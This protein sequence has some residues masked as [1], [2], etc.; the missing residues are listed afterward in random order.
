MY[1]VLQNMGRVDRQNNA[2]PGVC[3][4]EVHISFDS[5]ISLYI[6]IMKGDDANER[7]QQLS[8]MMEVL[9]FLVTPGDCYHTLLENYFEVDSDS[10]KEP[11]GTF[12]SFCQGEVGFFTKRF[13][14]DVVMSVLTETI[15]SPTNCPTCK[16]FI[17]SLKAKKADIF[18]LEDVPKR[19]MG[20]IHGVALQLF[21]KGI[22][23]LAVSDSTKIGAKDLNPKHVRVTL[24]VKKVNNATRPV[25]TIDS[26]WDGL[27]TI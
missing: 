23:G 10:T 26:S 18:H 14:K 13:L 12:C 15:F 5:V 9:Q 3:T 11:C 1:A 21:A 24:P 17:K 4:Y 25:Y 8:Q 19:L 16:S 6:Q 7:K 20:P 22:I 2:I 27:N